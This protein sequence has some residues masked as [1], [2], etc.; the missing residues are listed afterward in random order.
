MRRLKSQ[1]DQ[2]RVSREIASLRPARAGCADLSAGI[3]LLA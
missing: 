3:G 1:I 2:R